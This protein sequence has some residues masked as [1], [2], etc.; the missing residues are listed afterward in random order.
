MLANSAQLKGEL[1]VAE[2]LGS[3]RRFVTSR[4]SN[5]R[6]VGGRLPVTQASLPEGFPGHHRH[7]VLPTARDG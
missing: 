1:K 3:T 6:E 7:D 5:S 2:A 4:F